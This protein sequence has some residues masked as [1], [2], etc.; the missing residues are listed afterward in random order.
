[1]GG[2]VLLVHIALNAITPHLGIDVMDTA[3]LHRLEFLSAR[4]TPSSLLLHNVA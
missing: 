1:M 2:Q 4:F 3:G